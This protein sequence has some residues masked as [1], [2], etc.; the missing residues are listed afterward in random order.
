MH[1]LRHLATLLA[2]L[3]TICVVTLFVTVADQQLARFG[4]LPINPTVCAVALL[5]P[6]GLASSITSLVS[7]GP[8]RGLCVVWHNRHPLATFGAVAGV[9]LLLSALPHAY[10]LEGGKWIFLISYGFLIALLATF[11]PQLAIVR[12]NYA[13]CAIISLALLLWSIIVDL[14]TPGTFSLLNERAAGFPGNA[15]FAALVT[16]MICASALDYD[17]TAQP[18]KN[19][20]LLLIAGTIVCLSMSR[21]G[22]LNFCLL[23]GIFLF[24]RLS[25]RGFE[26]RAVITTLLVL[27]S[28][29]SICVALVAAISTFS[30]TLQQNNRLTRLLNNQQVDDGSAGTRLGAIRDSLRLINESPI[31]GHG[32][33]F[34]RTMDE[35]PHNLYL[36]QWV[37]NGV[38]GLL[39]LIA[40]LTTCFVTFRRRRFRPGQAF[41]LVTALGG[42]FSH[43]I[44][45]QRCFLITLGI[46]LGLSLHYQIPANARYSDAA[47]GAP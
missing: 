32:T 21:S 12:T 36:M 8:R 2:L 30:G 43:N 13:W 23:L 20:I 33:G 5:L 9:S 35:L 11:V 28:S 29:I 40:F 6:F 15:N 41:I 46:L 14:L 17:A 24:L 26:K 39:S 42:V 4:Y 7:P 31:V 34:S 37:N 19:T 22:V 44:L 18:L 16:V 25:D 47:C 10:W 3:Y 27:V 1:P 45:D 38:F